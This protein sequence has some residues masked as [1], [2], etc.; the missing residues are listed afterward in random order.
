ML[1]LCCQGAKA[2]FSDNDAQFHQHNMSDDILFDN[3]TPSEELIALLRDFTLE[4]VT[5]KIEPSKLIP[6]ARDYF[7]EM[8]AGK[9]SAPDTSTLLLNPTQRPEASKA[10]Q[11]QEEGGYS[12]EQ[13]VAFVQKILEA[14]DLIDA[15]IINQACDAAQIPDVAREQLISIVQDS[16]RNRDDVI[17]LAATLSTTDFIAVVSLLFDAFAGE[18]GL[19]P[20]RDLIDLHQSVMSFKPKEPLLVSK[21]GAAIYN[22]LL[23][24]TFDTSD[25][26][27]EQFV[28]MPIVQE[29]I[30]KRE[31]I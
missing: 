12:R 5:K 9:R 10:P 31:K 2:K 29:Y 20:I 23:S 19:L 8:A 6:F 7:A 15:N 17:V 13:F 22:Q 3:F 27:F 28:E 18:T 26:T 24:M 16:E 4:C 30:S 1:R 21:F 11:K 14:E 25:I